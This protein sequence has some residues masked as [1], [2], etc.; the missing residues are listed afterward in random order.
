M[1]LRT[2]GKLPPDY[3]TTGTDQRVC[4]FLRVEYAALLERVLAGTTDQVWLRNI[5]LRAGSG[6]AAT[7]SFLNFVS[8][9]PYKV[10][11]KKCEAPN[12]HYG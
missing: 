12:E 5:I 2:Q 3:K 1:R 8:Y 9:D 10:S 4:R 11:L 7:K 6:S